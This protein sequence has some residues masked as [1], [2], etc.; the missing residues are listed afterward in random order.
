MKRRSL[1]GAAATLTLVA[2]WP[3]PTWPQSRQRILT[4]PQTEGP[5]YPTAM[6]D[7]IDSDLMMIGGR[8]YRHGELLRM[9]GTVE[10]LAGRPLGGAVVEIWQCDHDGHYHH[11]GDGGRADRGFQ[12]YGRTQVDA[13]GRYAFTTMRPVPY[14]GRTPHIHVKVRRGSHTLLT[15]QMY[16]AGEPQN[17]RDGVLSAIKNPEQ[18]AALIVELSRDTGGNAWIADFPLIV[19]ART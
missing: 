7:K 13:A 12:G 14:P 9:R 4:P 3:T 6:P 8:A 16:V 15:T 11:P 2:A 17:A 5:F 19:D 1:V 10:D 18:R